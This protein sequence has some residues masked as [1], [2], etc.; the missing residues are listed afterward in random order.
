[1]TSKYSYHDTIVTYKHGSED[2]PLVHKNLKIKKNARL[3]MTFHHKTS[4][5]FSSEWLYKLTQK[6]KK[7]EALFEENIRNC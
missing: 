6:Y 4:P 7:N 2:F 3:Q 5:N 1:M